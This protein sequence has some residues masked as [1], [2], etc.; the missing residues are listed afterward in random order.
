MVKPKQRKIALLVLFFISVLCILFVIINN[1]HWMKRRK[2]PLEYTD[3][4]R[5]YSAVYE[6]DPFLTASII[7]TESGFNPE[8]VSVKNA[9]GLMQILPSTGKWVAD[10]IGLT[11]FNDV[12]LFD[13]EINIQIGC[14]YINYLISKFPD[15]IELVLAAYNGGIG[16]VNKWLKNKEYSKDGKKLDYI[17]FIETRNYVEKVLGVYNIYQEIYPGLE[18]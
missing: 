17:P 10:K 18:L 14:W 12:Q 3:Q 9:I 1:S 15:N 7:F 16:N 11:N 5:K 13:P 8:T 6:V 2:Y 4:I